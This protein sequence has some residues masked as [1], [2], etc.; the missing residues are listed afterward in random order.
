MAGRPWFKAYPR[1][2][3]RG[4]SKLS[5]DEV[6]AYAV[7]LMLIYEEGGPIEDSPR[8]IASQIGTGFP[9]RRWNSVRESLIA[10]GKLRVTS[11]GLLTNDRAEVELK[12]G[13]IE[14]E[15]LANNGS[16]GGE[17]SAKLRKEVNNSN[18][19]SEKG[20]KKSSS[21][22]EGRLQST[23]SSQHASLSLVPSAKVSPAPAEQQRVDRSRLPRLSDKPH[24]WAD[25]CGGEY[26]LDD[27]GTSRPSV[28]NYF[29]DLA[30]ASVCAA[31]KMND[32]HWRGDWDTV[33]RWIHDG[34][35]T[36]RALE[37]IELRV[38]K[39]GYKPPA[40][41]RYF[42]SLVR[43]HAAANPGR[44]LAREAG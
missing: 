25:L 28:G 30:C 34:I 38:A 8:W 11:N 32:P 24:L 12:N 21:I 4:I 19:L 22:A 16:K 7:I 5:S 29:I 27:Q 13:H 36:S 35:P 39:P 37:A 23:D 31:A 3:L 18:N 14:H 43:A 17:K 44:P 42:D 20:L 26:A 33:T 6:A 15:K 1:D 2:F 9:T 41:L 40:V 10:K